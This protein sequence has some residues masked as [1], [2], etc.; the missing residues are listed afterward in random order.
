MYSINC[1]YFCRTN[2]TSSRQ[3]LLL[4]HITVFGVLLLLFLCL[5]T[6]GTCTCRSKIGELNNE[7]IKLSRDLEQLQQ[8][9]ATYVTYE[10]R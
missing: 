4:G 1:K 6:T 3:V 2:E 7:I 8:D 10:K 9:S 5:K